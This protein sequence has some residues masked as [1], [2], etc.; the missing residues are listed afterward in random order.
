M[1]VPR[2]IRS[3]L[4]G[5]RSDPSIRTRYWLEVERR[6]PVDRQVRDARRAIGKTGWAALLLR[7]Q[8]PDGHWGPPGTSGPELFRPKYITTHWIAGVLADLG[9]T[10]KDPRIRKTAELI[11]AQY[12]QDG[13]D[14]PLDYRPGRR[15]E[16]C[17][18]GMIAR[19]LIRFGYL[20][21]PAV[22]RTIDWIVETQRPDGGWHHQPSRIG[23]LDA[24]EGLAAL[25]EIPD[26]QR[27]G[28]IRQSIERGAE[29]YLR[30]RLSNEGRGRYGP[31]FRVH[32]PNQNYYDL[33]LGLRIVTRLGYGTDRRLAPALK[34]LRDKQ[35]PDGAWPLDASAPDLPPEWATAY[36][37]NETV[38]PVLLEPLH[39]RSQWATVEALSILAATGPREG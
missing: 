2:R 11:L 3:W 36:Y 24:W 27:T 10:R 20:D 5:P 19:T 28:R 30:R 21:H 39:G 26:G 23:T 38:Y 7:Q 22:Q 15:G 37:E 1:R 18:T 14:S 8:W 35:L 31:W 4:T 17:V 34:W 29:F 9:M 32:Y 16:L 13:R 25:A 33:L 12:T 6:D